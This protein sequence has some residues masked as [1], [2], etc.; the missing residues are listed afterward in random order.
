M[1]KCSVP[2]KPR[3]KLSAR[4]EL[5]QDAFVGELLSLYKEARSNGAYSAAARCLQL[6]GHM[7]GLDVPEEK[8]NTNLQRLFEPFGARMPHTGATAGRRL[9]S[10]LAGEANGPLRRR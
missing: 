6:V 10:G 3:G 1:L 5:D 4:V 9:L 2:S 7:T 8:P